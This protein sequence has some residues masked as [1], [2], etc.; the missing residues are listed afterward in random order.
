[1]TQVK[2]AV[3]AIAVALALLL[4]TGA[5]A[6]AQE[7]TAP[8]STETQA[9]QV[10]DARKIALGHGYK[11]G[12]IFPLRNFNGLDFLEPFVPLAAWG[13]GD[14]GRIVLNT[15]VPWAMLGSAFAFRGTDLQ[16]LPE[17]RRW[18]WL[19][20]DNKQN[21]YYTLYS[22]I[23][24]GA[25]SVIALPSPE[26][27]DGINWGLRFDRAL[28][29]GLGMSITAAGEL[30]LKPIFDRTRPNGTKHTS[31]PSGHAITA[32]AAAAFLGDTLRDTFRPQDE[33]D[34]SIRLF[35]EIGCAL[36]YL[37]AFY[38]G[39]SRVNNNKHFLSDVLLGGAIGAFTMHLLYSW[40]FT[41]VEMGRGW[42]D[43]ASVGY[44]PE[45][46]GITFALVKTF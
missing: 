21:N 7:G 10:E 11:D 13:R 31:R 22:M 19:G 29:F 17:L 41:R 33:D 9:A 45:R 40:S 4:V 42:F 5:P 37:G 26:D 32:F 8:V 15:L 20:L 18:S 39:L 30:A 38:V 14:G 35:K 34:F 2:R 25:L 3:A 46:K 16:T 36:P 6:R 24:I 23:A 43:T 28:V 27:V 44:D 1:M 12:E